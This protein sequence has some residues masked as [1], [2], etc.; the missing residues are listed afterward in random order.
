MGGGRRRTPPGGRGGGEGEVRARPS[1][2][3]LET[4]RW[5]L[6]YL[7]AL[8]RLGQH[9]ELGGRGTQQRQRRGS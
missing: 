2:P 5:G 1:T 7:V 8:G 6:S 3:R 9:T 4:A